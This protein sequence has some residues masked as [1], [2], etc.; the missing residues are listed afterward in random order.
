MPDVLSVGLGG[1]SI[2]QH[3]QVS[4]LPI[5]KLIT[6]DEGGGGGGGVTLGKLS[7]L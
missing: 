3:S 5:V 4:L 1:G 2:V 6:V 7:S